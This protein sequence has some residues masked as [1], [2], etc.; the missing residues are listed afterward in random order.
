MVHKSAE[1]L[2]FLQI[3]LPPDSNSLKQLNSPK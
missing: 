1:A 3:A 2:L